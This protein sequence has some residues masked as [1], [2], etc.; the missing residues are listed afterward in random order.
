MSGSMSSPE[1]GAQFP[2][3][4]TV[5]RLQGPASL[6][7]RFV[8]FATQWIGRLWS[9]DEGLHERITALGEQFEAALYRPKLA[10]RQGV[11]QPMQ[12]LTLSGVGFHGCSPV[13]DDCHT[14]S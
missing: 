13:S 3:G 1:F 11:D 14:M 10:R 2:V 4:N 6:F 5:A 7:E 12:S 8:V 9:P